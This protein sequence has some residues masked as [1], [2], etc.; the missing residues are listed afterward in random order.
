MIDTD[1]FPFYGTDSRTAR[2][3]DQQQ[4]IQDV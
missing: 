2:D 4:I 1:T 3:P